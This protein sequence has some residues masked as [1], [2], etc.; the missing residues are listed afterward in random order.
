MAI[1]GHAVIVGVFTDRDNAQRAVAELRNCGFQEQQIGVASR[2]SP[3]NN[4]AEQLATR[5]SDGALAGAAAG[6]GVG[7][8]WGLAVIA[9]VLPGLGPVIAGGALAALVSSAAAGAVAAGLGA[10]LLGLGIPQQNVEFYE[11]QFRAGRTIVTV[12]GDRN[13]E[14][15]TILRRYGGYGLADKLSEKPLLPPRQEG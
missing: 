11:E 3:P 2:E 14:A 12:T 15:G 5:T 8:L 1:N 7:T 6:A 13:L 9:G 4:D 10:A